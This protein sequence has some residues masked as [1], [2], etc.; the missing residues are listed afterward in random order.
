MK[1]EE[2]LHQ[3][4]FTSVVHNVLE[5][6]SVLLLVL[7]TLSKPLVGR[8]NVLMKHGSLLGFVSRTHFKCLWR[9]GEGRG[10][11]RRRGKGRVGRGGVG[12]GACI[13]ANYRIP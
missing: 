1:E 13:F 12:R 5:V 7:L 10:G 11:E 4:T 8:S 6:L 9:G 3:L 2:Q